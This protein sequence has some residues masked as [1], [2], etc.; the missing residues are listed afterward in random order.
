MTY[1]PASA[2]FKSDEVSVNGFDVELPP[3]SALSG[4]LRCDSVPHFSNRW[5]HAKEG[6][7]PA[8]DD[9]FVIDEDLEFSVVPVFELY[10]L[11]QIIPYFSRRTGS[12]Q[13]CDSIPAPSDPDGHVTS[14][15]NSD[16]M[17]GRLE[18]DEVLDVVDALR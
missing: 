18:L 16:R 13:C 11:S 17:P 12:M 7:L 8:V 15:L 2:S 1:R 4:H 6:Q 3:I 10:V 9:L 14:R 5:Q